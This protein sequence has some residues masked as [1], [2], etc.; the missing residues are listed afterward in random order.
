MNTFFYISGIAF[1]LGAGV[2]ALYFI[3]PTV[4]KFIKPVGNCIS[5]IKFYFFGAKWCKER[6]MA[7]LYFNQYANRSG[8]RAHWHS[9]KGFRRL[10]Y[11]RFLKMAKADMPEYLEERRKTF[12][13]AAELNK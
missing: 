3:I 1:W 8:I 2:L 12:A 4:W 10:A 5:N 11:S 9:R 13:T 7:A 6:N